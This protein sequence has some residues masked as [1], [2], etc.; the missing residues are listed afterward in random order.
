MNRLNAR[1]R[2]IPPISGMSPTERSSATLCPA[3]SA[4][5]MTRCVR[6]HAGPA[7]PA[8]LPAIPYMRANLRW[9]ARLAA[10]EPPPLD[11]GIHEAL[12]AWMDQRRASVPDSDI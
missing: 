8:A 3:C 1:S 11:E 7:W 6:A 9:K 12:R 4:G 2:R 5:M 10:Y